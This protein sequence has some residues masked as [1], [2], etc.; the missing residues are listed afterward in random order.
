LIQKQL[1]HYI[2]LS[3]AK[4]VIIIFIWSNSPQWAGLPHSRGF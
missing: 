3:L 2:F 1:T 4:E